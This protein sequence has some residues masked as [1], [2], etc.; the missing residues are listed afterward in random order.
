MDNRGFIVG[1]EILNA[2][3]NLGIKEELLKSLEH[4]SMQVTY[5]PN[6]VYIAIYMKM[7][8]KEKEIAIP[9]TVDLGHGAVKT[10]KTHFAMASC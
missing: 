2:S 4:A 8:E 7:K 10:E 3:Q 9:L 1:L 6:Y 5:K